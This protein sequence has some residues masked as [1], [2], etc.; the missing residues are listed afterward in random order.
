MYYA[1]TFAKN[2]LESSTFHG[3]KTFFA[4]VLFYNLHV[5]LVSPMEMAGHPYNGGFKV[6]EDC[7]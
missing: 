5:T 6:S 2:V 4:N 7:P 1:K 3:S